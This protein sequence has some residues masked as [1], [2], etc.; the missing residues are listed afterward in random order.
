[1]QSINRLEHELTVVH[2]L[3]RLGVESYSVHDWFEILGE[4]LSEESDFVEM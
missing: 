4:E 1:L 3:R 2:L